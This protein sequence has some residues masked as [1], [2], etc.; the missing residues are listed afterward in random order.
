MN[1]Q[2]NFSRVQLDLDVSNRLR[3]L[4]SRT[5]LSRNYLCRIGLCYSLREPVPPSPEEYDSEGQE[6]NRYLLLGDDLA[7]YIALTQER[8]IEE[9][10]DPEK[11]FY[12][13]FVAHINR[14]VNQLSGRI[15]NLS[16]F[17]DLLPAEANSTENKDAIDS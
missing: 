11:E 2:T 1:K 9:G 13:H 5:G 7:L 15:N 14:G 8:L 16:D 6:L 12:E 4:K 17:H 10:K 3:N